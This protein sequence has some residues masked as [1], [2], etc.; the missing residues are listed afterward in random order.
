MRQFWHSSCTAEFLKPA[1]PGVSACF[2][3]TGLYPHQTPFASSSRD[4]FFSESPM[5]C[6]SVTQQYR[7]PKTAPNTGQMFPYAR[8]A[9]GTWV[10]CKQIRLYWQL[11]FTFSNIPCLLWGFDSFSIYQGKSTYETQA[12]TISCMTLG[13]SLYQ[14]ED[15]SK[16][17][18]I[19]LRKD[20]GSIKWGI[21]LTAFCKLSKES[22]IT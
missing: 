3:I 5:K 4:L 16:L 2:R 13:K 8:C 20:V 9:G 19:S 18:A 15:Q 10:G 11:L 14:S 17:T 12:F 7:A 21:D 22:R 1:F 6:H